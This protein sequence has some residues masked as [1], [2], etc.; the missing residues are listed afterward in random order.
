MTLQK[1]LVVLDDIDIEGQ[2]D[3]ITVMPDTSEA[4]DDVEERS[5]AENESVR[6]CDPINPGAG[7]KE[8]SAN[9]IDT[10]I[11]LAKIEAESV[12]SIVDVL[13][14]ESSNL[15]PHQ[16]SSST[17]HDED[18]KT[19]L[20]LS[21]SPSTTTLPTQEP[22]SP[23]FLYKSI[24]PQQ[25]AHLFG[26]SPRLLLAISVVLLSCCCNVIFLELLVRQ[27]PGI[28]NLVTAAQFLVIAVEGFFLTTRCGTVG[29]KVTAVSCTFQSSSA[30][31]ISCISAY[32]ISFISSICCLLHIPSPAS[33]AYFVFSCF[34]RLGY[35]SY[36]R[37][38]QITSAS[39]EIM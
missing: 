13:I 1:S 16:I 2:S 23:P 20:N 7:A 33:P 15:I 3:G 39:W 12:E 18:S 28:G 29:P 35:F 37:M 11:E 22:S 5:E 34:C 24:S 9:I 25:S 8:P 4:N 17:H 30:I 10:K 26:W 6:G 36:G 32:Y 27:D 31:P 21:L 19:R 14:E 38:F